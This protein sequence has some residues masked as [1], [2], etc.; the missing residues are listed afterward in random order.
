MGDA[1]DAAK[2]QIRNVVMGALVGAILGVVAD[3]AWFQRKVQFQNVKDI[4]ELRAVQDEREPIVVDYWK[5]KVGMIE[6]VDRIEREL[7]IR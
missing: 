3:R 2:L 4:A 6:R 5:F 1:L 7:G